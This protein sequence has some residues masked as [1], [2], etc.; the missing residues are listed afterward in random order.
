M[1]SKTMC[2]GYENTELGGEIFESKS[3]LCH[4]LAMWYQASTLASLSFYLLLKSQWGYEDM[5][6]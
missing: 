3:W 5:V 2:Y 6:R 4:C 1:L